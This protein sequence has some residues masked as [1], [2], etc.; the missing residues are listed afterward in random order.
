MG[1]K[2]K[3]VSSKVWCYYCDRE[4]DDE[5]ILVQH[6]K[7]KHFKCH[8]CH[9]KLSTAGGMAIHVLQVHKENVTKVPNAKPGR[10]STDIEIYGMQGIPPDVLA[11]H[12]GEEEEEV[13]SK[14]AKV[15]TSFPQLVG[16]VVPGQ[17]GVSYPPQS[18]LGMMQP[19]YSSAVPVPPAGWPVPP[20]P[21]PWYPQHAAVS[22]PP[23]AAVGYAQQPL[24]PV[25]NVRPPLASSTSPALQ[26][27]PVVPPGMPSST[28]PVTVSQPL[29]PVVN[30]NTTS[31]SSLFSAPIPSTSIALSS[32]AEIKGSV[33]AHSSA[34]TSVTNSYHVPSMQGGTLSNSHSYAS[35]P[36]TGGPSIGPPPVIANKAPA[37]QPAVN[38]VYLVWEDEAMSMEERRMSS[39]KYQVHDETSQVSY[40]Y[41][42][43]IWSWFVFSNQ[44]DRPYVSCFQI[45][46]LRFVTYLERYFLYEFQFF[47]LI[48]TK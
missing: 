46:C 17:L 18:T 22:I 6:Q 12:Y 30:N 24:F 11:A 42:F 1:K 31:Q 33:D 37:T 25:Q 15:D 13:P 14:M 45:S 39:V 9:K 47:F 4:F 28:P 48:F 21:Q 20:R 5:K 36:N 10:E 27:S 35:G 38:E 3:R 23:P 2:K 16:G 44:M 41:L 32:S 43:K 19:I 34:N 29:F 8:V 7:A 26:P 40:N